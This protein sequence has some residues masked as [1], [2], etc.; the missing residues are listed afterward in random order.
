MSQTPVRLVTDERPAPVRKMNSHAFASY[1]S[2][3][4]ARD[5]CLKESPENTELGPSHCSRCFSSPSL[6]SRQRSRTARNF[7]TP[8]APSA[9]GLTE[10]ETRSLAKQLGQKIWVRQKPRS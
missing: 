7:S 4:F 10:P 3:H 8:I 9:T 1:N 6:I 5:K 2:Q